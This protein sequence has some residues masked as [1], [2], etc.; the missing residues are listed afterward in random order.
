MRGNVCNIV[1][2]YQ[3]SFLYVI[4]G[5]YLIEINI[6][7]LFKNNFSDA[8]ICILLSSCMNFTVFEVYCINNH[9]IVKYILNITV[10]EV[11]MINKE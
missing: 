2:F 8:T 3:M 6:T 11:Q 5:V 1:T 7:T 10:F 4:F 9:I